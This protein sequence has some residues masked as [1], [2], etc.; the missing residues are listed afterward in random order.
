M[1][2]SI[3]FKPKKDEAFKEAFMTKDFLVVSYIKNVLGR[4][5]LITLD[6]NGA[7]QS[8]TELDLP[9]EGT[10]G[11]VSHEKK[12]NN[13]IYIQTYNIHTCMHIYIHAYI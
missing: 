8:S 10:L 11:L 13:F 4:M 7:P 6:D 1:K 12:S 2:Y 3:I 5:T 9:K